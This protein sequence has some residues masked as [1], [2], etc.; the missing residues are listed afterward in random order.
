MFS[1]GTPA[2]RA[3]SRTSAA[4]HGTGSRNT[5]LRDQTGEGLVDVRGRADGPSSATKPSLSQP[6]DPRP[7]A[8]RLLALAMLGERL[9]TWRRECEQRIEPGSSPD[10]AANPTDPLQS[11][12]D[13]TTPGSKSTSTQARRNLARQV[14]HQPQREQRAQPMIPRLVQKQPRSAAD[15]GGTAAGTEHQ[16]EIPRHVL[17]Q[18]TVS[19]QHL[20]APSAEADASPAPWR[21]TTRRDSTPADQRTTAGTANGPGAWFPSQPPQLLGFGR[22]RR[23]R[24][25]P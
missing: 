22:S 9:D 19:T 8:V 4:G 12:A 23:A 10:R 5:R 21:L 17:G 14:R 24:S 18:Q 20:A 7:H 3:A 11:L 15:H 1:I 25:R 16:P 2:R 13:W 6:S